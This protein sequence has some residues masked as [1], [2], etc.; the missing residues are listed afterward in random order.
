MKVHTAVHAE[1]HRKTKTQIQMNG[2]GS[3][4]G[5]LYGLATAMVDAKIIDGALSDGLFAN[6]ITSNIGKRSADVLKA[7]VTPQTDEKL[8]DSLGIRINEVRRMLNMLNTEGVARYIVNRD[9][10]GWLTFK[11]YIDGEKLGDVRDRLFIN[12]TNVAAETAGTC[13][14]FFYC[15]TCYKKQKLILPFETA[16]E[17]NFRCEA[18]HMLKRIDRADV[19]RLA[20]EGP[21]IDDYRS[22]VG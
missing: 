15:E 6:Y 7:L 19:E 13:N 11:W 16:S 21:S 18:G 14:D 5:A 10:K 2:H 4:N 17:T 3:K 12:D 1:T 9:N 22:E 20:Q 8:A